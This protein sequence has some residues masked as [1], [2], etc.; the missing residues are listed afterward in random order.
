MPSA[1]QN[2]E[3]ARSPP[4]SFI[5]G[6]SCLNSFF[7]VIFFKPPTL[8]LCAKNKVLDNP[9]FLHWMAMLIPMACCIA[10]FVVEEGRFDSEDRHKLMMSRSIFQCHFQYV[11]SLPLRRVIIC[12]LFADLPPLLT[13]RYPSFGTEFLLQYAPL[14]VSSFAT[15]VALGMI[16]KT[17]YEIMVNMAG[18]SVTQSF[19]K[20]A[21][22]R[23][24]I[25]L[26]IVSIL[27]CVVWIYISLVSIPAFALFNDD[28]DDW[29]SCVKYDFSTSS[30]YGD[31]VFQKLLK[32]ADRKPCPPVPTDAYPASR[33]ALQY[34]NSKIPI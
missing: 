29:F 7:L 30:Q 26:G 9:T 15:T 14:I 16:A 6:V 34:V 33:L 21:Q 24:V 10:S 28:L 19:L 18:R 13:C 11:P 31:K 23:V 4:I 5:L 20:N 3:G 22:N 32:I 2:F 25:M 1:F 17:V 12:P 8:L 27:V